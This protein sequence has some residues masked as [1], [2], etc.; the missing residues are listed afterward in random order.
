MVA[1]NEI[2]SLEK[3]VWNTVGVEGRF[4]FF[5][6]IARPA[7]VI[8]DSVVAGPGPFIGNVHLETFID[9]ICFVAEYVGSPN[10]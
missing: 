4:S 2:E 10:F 6:C 5:A 3:R 9:N 8:P 7:G 1:L